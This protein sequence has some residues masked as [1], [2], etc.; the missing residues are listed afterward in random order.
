MGE[1]APSVQFIKVTKECVLSFL[2]GARQR[3][4]MSG[5]SLIITMCLTSCWTIKIFLKMWKNMNWKSAITSRA[6]SRAR[7]WGCGLTPAV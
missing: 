4:I 2:E 1:N 3:V 6:M 7:G 5:W